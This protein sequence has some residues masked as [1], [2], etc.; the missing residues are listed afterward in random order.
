M[1]EPRPDSH[2]EKIQSTII[3]IAFIFRV[4]DTWLGSSRSVK[5]DLVN[6]QKFKKLASYSRALKSCYFH[7]ISF[8]FIQMRSTVFCCRSRL[9]LNSKCR[10]HVLFDCI[11]QI[12]KYANVQISSDVPFYWSLRPISCIYLKIL[13]LSL[14]D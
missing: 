4:R 3:V 5:V 8:V 11:F 6:R 2:I 7:Q 1:S 13:L 10:F 12:Q 9:S 14:L